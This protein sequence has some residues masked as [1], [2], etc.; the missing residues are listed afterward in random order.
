[1]DCFLNYGGRSHGR[2]TTKQ[3]FKHVGYHI[4]MERVN[5]RRC[6]WDVGISLRC[7]CLCSQSRIRSRSLHTQQRTAVAARVLLCAWNCYFPRNIPTSISVHQ[8]SLSALLHQSSINSG[9]CF[10]ISDGWLQGETIEGMNKW[11]INW[12]RW[13]QAL[14]VCPA[15]TVWG[16]NDWKWVPRGLNESYIRALCSAWTTRWWYFLSLTQND[17]FYSRR[18]TRQGNT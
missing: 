16:E 11:N 15:T 18:R 5:S 13:T 6:S 4:K 9:F 8:R 2:N 10:P 17:E 7:P 12:N 3:L 14:A 1:M